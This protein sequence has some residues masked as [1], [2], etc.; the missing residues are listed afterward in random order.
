M[1]MLERDGENLGEDGITVDLAWQITE[2]TK[3][4]FK[5]QLQ[6]VRRSIIQDRQHNAVD[7]LPAFRQKTV[8]DSSNE[9]KG[10]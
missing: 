6:Q 5:V 8:P 10:K 1:P 3:D 7:N 2:V 4:I 9:L